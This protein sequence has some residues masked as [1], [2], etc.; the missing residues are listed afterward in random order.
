MLMKMGSKRCLKAVVKGLSGVDGVDGFDG[1]DGSGG[2]GGVSFSRP[3]LMLFLFLKGR[4]NF[5]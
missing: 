3:I 2:D 1:V 4:S 5:E